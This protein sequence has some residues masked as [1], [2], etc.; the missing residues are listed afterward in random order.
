MM[1][2]V[3]HVPSQL[4]LLDFIVWSHALDAQRLDDVI[5]VVDVRS[6]VITVINLYVV[7]DRES[8]ICRPHLAIHWADPWSI[9]LPIQ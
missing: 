7:I 1:T 4:L 9:V 5:R 6:E 8:H 3:R 2:R